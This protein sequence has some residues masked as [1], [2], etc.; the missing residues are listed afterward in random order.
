MYFIKVIISRAT[1]FDGFDR[2]EEVN[3]K[4]GSEKR[5]LPPKFCKSSRNGVYSICKPCR[6]NKFS[7]SGSSLIKNKSSLMDK[8]SFI[9][10]WYI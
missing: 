6:S 5:F 7:G 2:E 10:P 1:T 4:Q 3:E 8:T 9:S